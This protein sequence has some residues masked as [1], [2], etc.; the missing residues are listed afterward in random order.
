VASIL[1]AISLV[2]VEPGGVLW[3]SLLAPESSTNPDRSL[4]DPRC[5]LGR[6]SL[7]LRCI[8][9]RTAPLERPPV[10]LLLTGSV[11]ACRRIS[12]ID[13][14]D[15][16]FVRRVVTWDSPTNRWQSSQRRNSN[17]GSG[18]F[19]DR[20][21]PMLRQCGAPDI[22]TNSS[23][24]GPPLLWPASWYVCSAIFRPMPVPECGGPRIG[25]LASTEDRS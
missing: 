20:R 17:R 19:A 11:V 10:P 2:W 25:H 9:V 23:H 13:G 21:L 12:R 4:D 22:L 14:P 18:Q 8:I 24:M 1:E 6:Y 7:G 5:W 16:K 15:H 3:L